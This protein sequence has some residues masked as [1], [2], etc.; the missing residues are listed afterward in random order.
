MVGS[1][2]VL[3]L[4]AKKQITRFGANLVMRSTEGFSPT[5]GSAVRPP[6]H[7]SVSEDMCGAR[8]LQLDDKLAV[9]AIADRNTWGIIDA[10]VDRRSRLPTPETLGTLRRDGYILPSPQP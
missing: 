10:D 5:E 9:T 1:F 6:K 2:R 3:L 4:F 7:N 8:L